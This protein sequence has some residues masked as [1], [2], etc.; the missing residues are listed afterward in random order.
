MTETLGQRLKARR[1]ELGLTLQD[2][3][4]ECLCSR[5]F[6]HKIEKDEKKWPSK[7]GDMK[8]ALLHARTTNIIYE[9]LFKGDKGLVL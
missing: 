7:W 4:D 2:V 5:Q 8:S 1:L 6:I 3:A 9:T